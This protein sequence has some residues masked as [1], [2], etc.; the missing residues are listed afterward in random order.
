[1]VRGDRRMR[2]VGDG[3]AAMAAEVVVVV[4]EAVDEAVFSWLRDVRQKAS[5]D[6][7]PTCVLVTDRFRP[8]TVL[9]AVHCGVAA[10]LPRRELAAAQLGTIVASVRQGAAHFSIALQGELLRQLD[11][12]RI[13]V[14]EPNGISLQ[15]FSARERDV[16]KGLAE[17]FNTDE[18]AEST[19]CSER[20]V[21]SVLYDLMARYR[22]QTRAQVAA[23]AVRCGVA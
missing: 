19:G 17:G 9:V 1:M 23:Y 11:Q 4:A 14:L 8:S 2:L 10:V 16:L 22:L 3:S 5:P 20:T 15:G 21:K 13:E 12:M 7:A 6:P 18:I